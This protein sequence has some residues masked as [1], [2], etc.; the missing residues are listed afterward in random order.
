VQRVQVLT[1]RDG[2]AGRSIARDLPT[3]IPSFT[4]PTDAVLDL[5]HADDQARSRFS[6]PGL[7]PVDALWWSDGDASG[8]APEPFVTD[9]EL[10]VETH[11]GWVGAD[12]GDADPDDAVKQVS[13]LH[14]SAGTPLDEFRSHYRDHVGVARRHMPA[15]WQ[16]RQHD[17]IDVGG[18]QRDVGAGIV[19]VSE[20]WFRSVDD[21]VHRYFASPQ[22]EAE[23]R[24]HE[25]FLDLAK[26][27]SFVCSSHALG[28]RKVGTRGP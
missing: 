27:F 16:Y 7:L 24:S 15:L 2:D 17:V 19:A 22:D 10:T 26:A 1:G 23:F 28:T 21:F 18:A 5:P 9:L 6:R 3:V 11:V 25:G 13:F 12:V 20:L 14:A 4:G 8:M